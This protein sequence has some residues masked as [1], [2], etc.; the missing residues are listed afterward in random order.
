MLTNTTKE[1]LNPRVRRTR[2]LLEQA[3]MDVI[4]EKGFSSP[5]Q[6]HGHMACHGDRPRLSG[7]PESIW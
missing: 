1:R 3:F 4:A 2:Q 5:E 7:M 6:Q